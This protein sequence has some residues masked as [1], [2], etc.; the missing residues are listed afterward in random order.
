MKSRHFISLPL[1][2]TLG[3]A[4][5][6]KPSE[7]LP[8]ETSIPSGEP[9]LS[10]ESQTPTALPLGS[11]QG[12]PTGITPME[13]TAHA[14]PPATGSISSPTTAPPLM[15]PGLPAN[16]LDAIKALESSGNITIQE[17]RPV[18][19]APGDGPRGCDGKVSDRATYQGTLTQDPA[20]S[21]GTPATEIQRLDPTEAPALPGNSKD[22]T[23]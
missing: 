17:I 14:E 10:I 1:I 16:A 15:P 8:S 22:E 6:G 13:V 2:A 21:S 23:N 3:F 20:V 7:T 11:G 5:C 19:V 9:P 4:G 18:E 12:N